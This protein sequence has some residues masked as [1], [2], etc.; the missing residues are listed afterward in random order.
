MLCTVCKQPLSE[1]QFNA[2]R[3]MKSCPSCSQ[4]NGKKH[5]FYPCPENFGTTTHRITPN[6][7]DGLQS[8][9]TECRGGSMAVQGGTL[10]VLK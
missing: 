6:N 4:R 3:T 7:P 2:D 9:C 8:H 1:A 10:C 5:V